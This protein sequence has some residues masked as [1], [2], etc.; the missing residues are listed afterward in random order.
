MAIILF[1]RFKSAVWWLFCLIVFDVGSQVTPKLLVSNIAEWL[2]SDGWPI[3]TWLDSTHT[4]SI[5]RWIVRSLMSACVCY[6]FWPLLSKLI[7][8]PF[9]RQTPATRTIPATNPVTTQALTT[10]RQPIST[11][12]DGRVIA[13]VSPEYLCGFF[14]HHMTI[15]AQKLIAPFVGKWMKISG[16]LENVNDYSEYLSVSLEEYLP[17]NIH[18]IFYF[19]SD[20][21][22]RLEILKP[23][24]QISFIGQIPKPNPNTHSKRFMILEECE[25]L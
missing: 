19:N 13:N 9:R 22:N 20:C 3:P 14:E 23:G 5:V 10:A 2:H 24:D 1:K 11:L 15:H 4:D 17:P 21:K 7:F 25:L 16:R 12:S 18:V 8:N 6:V